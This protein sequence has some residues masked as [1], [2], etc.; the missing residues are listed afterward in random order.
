MKQE[1]IPD[2]TVEEAA[3]EYA[4]RVCKVDINDEKY[5]AKTDFKEGVAWRDKQ[6]LV[7]G[8]SD[9]QVL[10]LM[11]MTRHDIQYHIPWVSKVML[12]EYKKTHSPIQDTRID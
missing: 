6:V 8:W 11:E 4:D 12:E 7:G 5:K 10:E 9:T 1:Q 2:S 3:K